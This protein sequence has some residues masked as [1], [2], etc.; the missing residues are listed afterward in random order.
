LGALEPAAIADAV[1]GAILAK[2]A[3]VLNYIELRPIRQ[4]L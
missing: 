1:L 3:Q 4:V 2:P